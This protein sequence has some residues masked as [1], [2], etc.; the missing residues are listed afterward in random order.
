MV[1][2]LYLDFDLYEPTRVAL[3]VLM[4]RVVPGGVV[5]FDE[6]ACASYPGETRALRDHMQERLPPLRRF[7]SVPNLAYFVK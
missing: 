5:C 4:E 2:L 6:L 7:P 1:S 3:D